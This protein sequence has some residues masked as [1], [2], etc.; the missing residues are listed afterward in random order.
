[1]AELSDVRTMGELADELKALRARLRLTYKDLER[2]AARR[3]GTLGTG[4]LHDMLGRHTISEEKLRLYL[5]ACEVAPTETDAWVDAWRRARSGIP[6]GTTRGF[7]RH[8]IT[9]HTKLFAGR[10]EE[11]ARILG[12]VRDRGTGYVFVEALSGYG[13][14]SLLAHLVDRHPEFVYH[15]IHQGDKRVGGGFDPTD[16][17]DVLSNV[18]E[19]LNPAHEHHRDLRLLEAEFQ[20]LLA[21][22]R[23]RPTVIVL[24]GID[25]LDPPGRQLRTLLPL[26]P[27]PGLVLILSARKWGRERGDGSYLT[28][29]GLSEAA[30]D[31]RLTLPGL[32]PDAVVELLRQ[33][34]G[35]HL[36]RD[37]DFVAEL[38]TVSQ[39]DPF[40]LRFLVEDVAAGTLTPANVDRTPTGLEDYLDQQFDVLAR[41]AHRPQHVEILGFL[42]EAEVLSQGDLIALIDGLTWLNFRGIVR[43]IQRFLLVHDDQYTFCHDRFREY[44]KSKGGM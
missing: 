23:R 2:R 10:D 31:L 29:V 20:E 22:E 5:A 44:F 36:A 1:M 38:H 40:Y 15:F 41:S 33:A 37:G 4:T 11:A 12:F 34:G 16:P 14:T 26:R 19:Q 7:F 8:L 9:R 39:G 17:V 24:D 43:E 28:D 18:C 6:G 32:G 35:Q 30:V 13:K 3:G 21:R 25:E 42:L 27:P